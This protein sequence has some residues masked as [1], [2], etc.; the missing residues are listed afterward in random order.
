MQ[1]A[2][3]H[4]VL[5]MAAILPRGSCLT[6]TVQIISECNVQMFIINVALPIRRHI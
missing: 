1:N 3:E 5:E 6:T 4:V 2:F